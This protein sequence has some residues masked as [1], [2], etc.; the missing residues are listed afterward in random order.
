MLNEKISVLIIGKDKDSV[1]NLE[2]LISKFV[3][4]NVVAK[5]TTGKQGLSLGNQYVPQLLII[6]DRLCDTD[7][8]K[9]VK[10]LQNKGIDVEVVFTSENSNFAHQSMELKPL[11]FWVNPFDKETVEKMIMRY[12]QK[13]K[14][15]ELFRKMDKFITTQTTNESHIFF[16]KKGVVVLNPAEI[17]FGKARLTNTILKLQTGDDVLLKTKMIETLEILNNPD[18]LRI[19]RSYFINRAYLWKIDK[20]KLKCILYYDGATWEVPVSKSTLTSL[21]KLNAHPIY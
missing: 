1:L 6:N 10:E 9:F 3:E 17:I 7:G 2:R 5:A 18:F 15:K 14:K 19:G 12:K 21:D 13:V 11:D 20:K 16:Q 4:L 8:L